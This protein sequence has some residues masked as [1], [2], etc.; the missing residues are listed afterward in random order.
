M[1]GYGGNY[2]SRRPTSSA[3]GSLSPTAVLAALV[4]KLLGRSG[5][6]AP[7]EN[8]YRP[9]SDPAAPAET[10]YTASAYDGPNAYRGSR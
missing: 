2:T 8:P 7:R 1:A 3:S 6:A 10:P 9:S 5:H 4:G